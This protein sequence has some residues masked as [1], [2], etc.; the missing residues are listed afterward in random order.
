MRKLWFFLMLLFYSPFGAA[1]YYAVLVNEQVYADGKLIEKGNAIAPETKLKFSSPEAFVHVISPTSGQFILSG[2][3]VK[4][5]KKGEF[6]AA[7][8]EAIIPEG[9]FRGT[10]TRSELTLTST[11]FED[12]YDLKAFFKDKLVFTDTLAFAFT[13]DRFPLDEDHMFLIRH[14]LP[15]SSVDH[16]LLSFENTTYL[17]PEV[18]QLPE[19]HD[20]SS[21][22]LSSELVHVDLKD[23]KETTFGPFTLRFLSEQEVAELRDELKIL[24]LHLSP[25]SMNEF[26]ATHAAPFLDLYYGNFIKEDLLAIVKDIP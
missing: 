15:D 24:Y 18:M 13:S 1:Q 25:K 3:K 10:L 19:G 12:H 7:L 22:V 5:N 2:K 23:E 8:K 26:L 14:T 21:L 4:Q 11:N 20:I 9:Q 16:R 17:P 6:L